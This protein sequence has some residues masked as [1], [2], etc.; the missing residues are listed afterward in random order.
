MSERERYPAGVPCWVDTAQRDPDSALRFYGALF[1]WQF[2]GPGQMAGDPHGAYY[3]ARLGG[4]DVA[5]IS[6][7]P[8]VG[9]P[10]A[11]VWT[12][13]VAV[14]SADRTAASVRSAGGTVIVPPFDA[15]P[16]GRMAVLSDPTGAVFCAWEA[17]D[18]QGAQLVNEP[19]AW[20]MS[21]LVTSDP[22]ACEA[23][24]GA[25][26][27]WQPDTL[28]AKEGGLTFW[29]LPGYVGG[30]PQQPGPRDIV[31]LMMPGRDGAP[32]R[33]NVDFWIDDADA[34]AAKA[35]TMGGK[36]I[37]PPHDVPMFR[38]AVLQDPQGAVFSVSQLIMGRPQGRTAGG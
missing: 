6:S 17:R 34:A 35:V 15:P 14:A 19:R 12:T 2:S 8:R 4:R 23:F 21:S 7:M 9:A 13:H 18:R 16:A 36:A 38:N 3:V 25:V 30:E 5:G 33:W 1:G 29:R 22:Q 20:A 24:Y 37:V 27:G 10:P 11:P 26:F 31:A 28:G 32:S